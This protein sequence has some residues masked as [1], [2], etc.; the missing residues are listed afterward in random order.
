MNRKETTSGLVN[1]LD[2]WT[3]DPRGVKGGFVSL[4]DHLTGQPGTI[5][6]FKARPGISYSLRA[7][8]SR[9]DG[10]G[11]EEAL[12]ALVDVIDDEP[13][14]RWISVCFYETMINDPDGLGELIPGGLLGEDGYCFNLEADDPELLAYLRTRL[15][16]ARS[17]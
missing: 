1:F 8:R 2:Q 6:S 12:F 14:Q 3:D 10:A 5:L 11:E 13:D 9:G 16:E 17:A 7:S 15:D 4:M